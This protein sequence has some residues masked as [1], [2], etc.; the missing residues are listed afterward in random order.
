MLCKA[1]GGGLTHLG[2]ERELDKLQR[3]RTASEPNGGPTPKVPRLLGYVKHPGTGH[4]I[5]LLREWIP[6][7]C[8]RDIDMTLFL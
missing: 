5:G 4:I 8:L 7:S 1:S 3:L 6:G 2:L